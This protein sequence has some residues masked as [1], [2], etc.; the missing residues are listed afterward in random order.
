MNSLQVFNKVTEDICKAPGDVGKDIKAKCETVVLGN[1]DLQQT[2]NIAKVL[3]GST[4]AEDIEMKLEDVACF[5]YAPVT[6][7]EVERTF[8]QLKI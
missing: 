6:S 4:E 8:S 2:K 5:K 1:K 3:E 7:V